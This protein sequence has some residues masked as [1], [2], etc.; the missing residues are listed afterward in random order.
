MNSGSLGRSVAAPALTVALAALLLAGCPSNAPELADTKH[1]TPESAALPGGLLS[2]VHMGDPRAVPQLLEGFYGLEQG[3]WRWTAR[4]FSVALQAPAGG[5]QETQLEFK[6]TLPEA[7]MSRL[8]SV[9]LTARINNA[10]VGSESYQKQG[11][12]VFTK[13][14]PAGVLAG[15]EA[16]KVEFELDKALPPGDAD[17]REL[18]LI[19]VSVALK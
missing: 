18:G 1:E 8:G 12:Y 15:G 16:V 11:E 4:K 5:G 2:S 9:T 6:F 13:P 14:V 17:K 7:V 19:A 10:G 3:V